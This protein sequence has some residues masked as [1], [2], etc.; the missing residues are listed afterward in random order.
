MRAAVFLDRDG[1]INEDAGYVHQV[2]DFVWID[3]ARE[4]I[5]RFNAAGLVVVVVTN[6]GGIAHGYYTEAHV[7]TLHTWMHARLAEAGARV[8]AVYYAPT[9]PDG[10]VERY[11]VEHADRK[12]GTGMFDQAIRDLSLDAARSFMVGDKATDLIPARALGMRAVLVETGHGRQQGEGVPADLVAPSLREAA[13]W[14]LE[15][16][17]P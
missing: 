10:V 3:G 8:D 5:A 14:I 15:R 12:P 9:H 6:Q 7:E 13:D 1:T 4:A 2:E 17:A 16:A 11:T